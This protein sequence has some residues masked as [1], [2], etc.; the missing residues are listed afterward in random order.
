MNE[1]KASRAG[2]FIPIVIA[3]LALAV[4][5]CVCTGGG[6]SDPTPAA[7]TTT[8]GT[9][10]GGTTT[11]TEPTPAAGDTATTGGTTTGGTTTGGTTDG[12]TTTGGTTDAGTTDGSG[13]ETD[14]EIVNNT[15]SSIC[16][17]Y[18]ASSTDATDWGDEVLGT[19][20]IIAAGA[21]DTVSG[22][23]GV[24]DIILE[25]C[26]HNVIAWNY[27]ADL[28]ADTTLTVSGSPDTLIVQNNSSFDIC[29]LYI[30]SP[31][32]TTFGRS[33]LNPAHPIAAGQ[34]RSF[35]VTSGTWDLR[36]QPCDESIT[37]LDRYGEDLSGETTWTLTNE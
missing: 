4:V 9:T 3:I 14:L 25:D 36:A 30:S 31:D 15:D 16:Y 20:V 37:P 27:G 33:H 12:T 18:I 22:P 29:G 13:E 24:Y 26:D 34:T 8:G 19:D 7:G 5:A 1:V 28:T 10:T 2:R 23:A 35:A 32:E 21:T 11:G 17:V 6:A